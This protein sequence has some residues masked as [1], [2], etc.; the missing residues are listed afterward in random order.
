MGWYSAV[1]RPLFFALPPEAAHRVAGGLLALPLPWERIGGSAPED[2]RLR[3]TI[4]GIPIAN[5]IGLAAG[6]DK[7]CAHLGT[8]GRLGFGYVVGGTVTNRPRRGHPKPRIVRHPHEGA[9]VN[10]MGMP[11]PGAAAVFRVLDLD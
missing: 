3:V 9:L 8:L 10:A 5:P 2:P 1:G 11:N 4:A 6:F 7:P